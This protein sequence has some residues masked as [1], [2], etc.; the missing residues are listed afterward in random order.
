MILI[1]RSAVRFYVNLNNCIFTLCF[2]RV[3]RGSSIFI[4]KQFSFSLSFT[5]THTRTQT[6]FLSVSLKLLIHQLVRHVID[7]L[8]A[9]LSRPCATLKPVIEPDQGRVEHTDPPFR[10]SRCYEPTATLNQSMKKPQ[11]PSVLCKLLLKVDGGKR[12]KGHSGGAVMNRV[13]VRR[14]QLRMVMER[15]GIINIEL[16]SSR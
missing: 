16:F 2:L 7:K 11:R 3:L 5:H 14:E 10:H 6:L 8:Q 4:R 12:E 9:R 1:R 13:R 15:Y